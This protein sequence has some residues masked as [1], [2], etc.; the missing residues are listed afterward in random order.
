VESKKRIDVWIQ[1]EANK[2]VVMKALRKTPMTRN[3]LIHHTKL[4]KMQIHN[5]IKNLHCSGYIRV[6]QNS[7][8]VCKVS[9]RT[10]RRYTCTSRKY[11][12]KDWSEIK[13]RSE[14]AKEKREKRATDKSTPRKKY[15]MSLRESQIKKEEM[16]NSTDKTIIKVNEHTTIYLN[17]KRPLSDYSWQRKR[18]H[19]V[20]SIGSGMDMFGTWS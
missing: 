4:S 16:Y 17:S 18:K 15:D 2:L 6:V 12:P 1:Y 14:A 19:T 20:V 13:Q 8:I 3:E 10:M 11:T 7:G 9:G 5:M